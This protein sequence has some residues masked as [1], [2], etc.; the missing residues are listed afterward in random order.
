MRRLLLAAICLL[1]MSQTA[2]AANIAQAMMQVCKG[3]ACSNNPSTDYVGDKTDYST[4]ST[5]YTDDDIFCYLYTAPTMTCDTGTFSYAYAHGKSGEGFKVCIYEDD[6]DGVGDSGDAKVGCVSVTLSASTA[7][8]TES[9]TELSQT[10]TKTK[11]YW[12][13]GISKNASVITRTA[14]GT[15]TLYYK[16]GTYYESPPDTLPD[17]M[18]TTASRDASIYVKVK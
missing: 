1:L 7:A 18:S 14:S 3:A 10:A 9:A 11:D 12:V 13:C 4:E 6:G 16:I 2:H 8:F 15:R 17:S 5:N